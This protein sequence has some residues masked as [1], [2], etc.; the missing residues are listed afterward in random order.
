[1]NITSVAA[2]L[3]AAVMLAG[4][5]ALAAEMPPASSPIVL[6]NVWIQ[7]SIDYEQFSPGF[8]NVSFKNTK[9][10]PATRVVFNLIGNKGALIAQYDDVGSFRQGVTIRHAFPQTHFDQEQ[11]LEV[12]HVVFADGTT[13]SG[14]V[15][16]PR[17]DTIFAPE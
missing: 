14:P 16:P 8:V 13:W 4:T 11:R 10:V 3:G 9:G 5:P 1:M 2:V 17:L 15:R 6:D 12:D 7:Q